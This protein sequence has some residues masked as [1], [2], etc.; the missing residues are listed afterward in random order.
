MAKAKKSREGTVMV[1]GGGIA[2]AGDLV[3]ET[4]RETIHGLSLPASIS[5]TPT[6]RPP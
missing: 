1:L 5:N 4:V 3:L 6:S 2:R